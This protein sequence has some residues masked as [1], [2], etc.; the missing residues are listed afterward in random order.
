MSELK[1]RLQDDMKE[2][3]RAKDK[4]RLLVIRTI[5][6]AMKQREVDERIELTD[7]DVL[8]I[9]D[10]LCKQRRESIT[11]FQAA[12]R[13]DLVDVEQRELLVIQTYLPEQLSEEALKAMVA[14]AIKSSGAASVQDMGK[15]MAIIKP[16]AQGRADMA[17]VS[18]WI[19]AALA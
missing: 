15:V 13:Q 12:S 7:A 10:K 3:M 2:A 16:K 14:E 5:L 8:A 1:V 11:Q 18:K 4:D 19:K 17:E 6:A 9:L